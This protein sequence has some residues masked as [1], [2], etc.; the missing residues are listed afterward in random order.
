LLR[1][2]KMTEERR[3]SVRGVLSFNK[4]LNEIFFF[5]ISISFAFSSKSSFRSFSNRLIGC[6]RAGAHETESIL[7]CNIFEQTKS[8]SSVTQ[9]ERERKKEEEREWV[10]GQKTELFVRG[11][12]LLDMRLRDFQK[13]DRNVLSFHSKYECKYE[14]EY[15]YAR[16]ERWNETNHKETTL[17]EK[18]PLSS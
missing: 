16:E 15:E 8:V 17:P 18:V 6:I 4:S 1:W 7:S 12:F 13:K 3:K 14:F 11:Y 9:R 2:V 5:A 10:N